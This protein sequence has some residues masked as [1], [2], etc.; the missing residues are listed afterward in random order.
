MDE[1]N[2]IPEMK[3]DT[4]T[5]DSTAENTVEKGAATIETFDYQ[6]YNQVEKNATN[7]NATVALVLGICSVVFVFIFHP[8]SIIL[9]I[10]GVVFSVKARKTEGA[11]NM[12][13]AALVC[14]I[15]GIVLGSLAL[16][17]TI[18]FLGSALSGG[19]IESII[20]ELNGGGY[21]Y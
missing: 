18:V 20:H 3:T 19:A 7:N 15:V 2:K 10:I 21:Y 12:T 4:N 14:S 6:T 8:V 13:T 11:K 16:L 9:G 17:C 5:G 1:F